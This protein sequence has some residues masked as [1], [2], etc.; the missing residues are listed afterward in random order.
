MLRQGYSL[1]CGHGNRTQD[2]FGRDS[3]SLADALSEPH[4]RTLKTYRQGQH[5]FKANRHTHTHTHS[6]GTHT[7]RQTHSQGTHTLV[8]TL[9]SRHTHTR[10]TNTV[11]HRHTRVHT[12]LRHVQVR[13]H[14][15]RIVIPRKPIQ[16]FCL[17]LNLVPKAFG[18]GAHTLGWV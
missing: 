15:L 8:H 17:S 2:P 11:R 16:L 1:G 9:N 4:T 6:Q 7:L 13:A 12:H 18:N 3:N 14:R 10:D 5:T